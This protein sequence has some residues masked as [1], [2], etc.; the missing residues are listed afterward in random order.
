MPDHHDRIAFRPATL[1]DLPIL[2]GLRWEMQQE[3]HPE[4]PLPE[5]ARAS[6]LAAYA[7]EMRGEME[8]DRMRAWLAV[9]DGQ[10][11]AAVTLLWWVV[12]P[13]IDQP[14]RRRGQVSNVFTRPAYRRRGL[15]RQLMT[16][17]IAHA[18]ERGI[19]RLILWPSRMGEPLYRGLGFI[20]SQGM[21][22][23]L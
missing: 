1:D 3:Q 16:L 14:R 9:V 10:P 12:P 7:L 11:V 20:G 2:F 17:L 21:E 6:Y 15:S 5:S 8:R 4:N 22:L 19:S 23:N 13:T 18:R